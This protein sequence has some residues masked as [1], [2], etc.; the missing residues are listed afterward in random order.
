MVNVAGSHAEQRKVQAEIQAK[1]QAQAQAQTVKEEKPNSIYTNQPKTTVNTVDTKDAEK[2]VIA[3]GNGGMTINIAGDCN[4]CQFETTNIYGDLVE[5][6]GDNNGSVSTGDESPS[7]NNSGNNSPVGVTYGD[8]SN[9][10][11]A[12]G[13]NSQIHQATIKYLDG[14]KISNEAKER[15]QRQDDEVQSNL[16]ENMTTLT[17][18]AILRQAKAEG[19]TGYSTPDGELSPQEYADQFKFPASLDDLFAEGSKFMGLDKKDQKALLESGLSPASIASICEAGFADNVQYDKANKILKVASSATG[20]VLSFDTSDENFTKNIQV[21]TV[22]NE[23]YV[24]YPNG[25]TKYEHKGDEIYVDGGKVS[26]QYGYNRD[27]FGDPASKENGS[28]MNTVYI[29]S[30]AQLDNITLD[31]QDTRNYLFFAKTNPKEYLANEKRAE[32]KSN[33]TVTFGEDCKPSPNYEAFV[34]GRTKTNGIPTY[35]PGTTIIHDPSKSEHELEMKGAA[36][37]TDLYCPGKLMP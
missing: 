13:K 31:R 9:V 37:Y 30:R 12:T 29:G 20:V 2:Q 17:R 15:L 33:F 23:G 25:M 32:I 3:D 11:Q 21:G 4:E 16:K 6:H 35:K 7:I 36:G 18:E 22:R 10:N 28:G 5:I 24:T 8:D 27:E 26:V 34:L 1:K 19:L 14:L